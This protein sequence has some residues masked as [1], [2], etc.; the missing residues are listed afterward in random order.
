M[1]VEILRI[2]RA[3]LCQ[4]QPLT[5]S[6]AT[7]QVL[8]HATGADVVLPANMYAAPIIT[9]QSPGKGAVDWNRMIK[10]ATAV[11]GP[12]PPLA[13]AP[14]T[15][16]AQGTLVPCFTAIG[17]PAM[18]LPDGTLVRWHPPIPGIEPVSKIV[19]NMTGGAPLDGPEA[20]AALVPI[21]GF[22]SQLAGGKMLQ[23]GVGQW[24]AVI[25]SWE[26]ASARGRQR[27]GIARTM[28]NH[29]WRC[30][31]IIPRYEGDHLRRDDAKVIMAA[32]SELLTD[33]TSV[34]GEH[35]A[36]LH[37]LAGNWGRLT[38][39]REFYAYYCDFI[40]PHAVARRDA[41]TWEKFDGERVQIITTDEPGIQPPD[42]PIVV[43]DMTPT[44]G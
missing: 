27:A 22:S 21:E 2:E 44:N 14:T 30:Y 26:S 29:T 23:A 15:V 5:G 32:I 40:L 36:S 12:Q 38:L 3:L 11:G 25:V 42:P 10:T 33:A 24:P 17:G 18:N 16:T 28:Y 9:G 41:R 34:D 20:V 4:L 39:G 8:V 31:V 7:G 35:F 43:V 1:S 37:V 19:G 6:R 13:P